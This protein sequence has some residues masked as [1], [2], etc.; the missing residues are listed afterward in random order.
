MRLAILLLVL[1][2]CAPQAPVGAA[3]EPL[4]AIAWDLVRVSEDATYDAGRVETWPSQV[5]PSPVPR[6]GY[7]PLEGGR[8]RNGHPGVIYSP[9]QSAME[10]GSST[11]LKA[12]SHTHF[13]VEVVHHPD[14]ERVLQGSGYYQYHLHIG[15]TDTVCEWLGSQVSVPSRTAIYHGELWRPV[16]TPLARPQVTTYEMRNG[17]AAIWRNGV[18]LGTFEG[19]AVTFTTYDAIEGNND[20]SIQ[21]AGYRGALYSM[22]AWF[23]TAAG[24]PT[25]AQIE[26]SQ[27]ARMEEYAIPSSEWT[28][29]NAPPTLWLDSRG[30]FQP[31]Q[32]PWLGGVNRISRWSN[33]ANLGADVVGV[34]SGLWAPDEGTRIN[35]LPAVKIGYHRT[36]APQGTLATYVDADEYDIKAIV[37][38][39][40]VTSTSGVASY[41]R[42]QLFAETASGVLH[43]FATT[44]AGVP[45]LGVGHYDGVGVGLARWKVAMVPVTLGASGLLHVSY[46]GTTLSAQ[47]ND[48]TAATV[49]AAPIPLALTGAV[50]IG[51]GYGAAANFTGDLAALIVRDRVLTAEDEAAEHAWLMGEYVP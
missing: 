29:A 12:G 33:Q 7:E 10:Y 1:A 40:S 2:A 45:H 26:A 4:S 15:N 51:S 47:W 17:T 6:A 13:V 22:R 8:V 14:E 21:L 48:E 34:N 27:R 43:V 38:L 37:R 32:V 35:G 46:D 16:V 30:K 9:Q 36:L 18:R 23:G 31:P 49:S 41:L 19:P 44:V 50:R 3:R 24:A 39:D 25:P 11:Q 5:G 20:V 28:P 42:D